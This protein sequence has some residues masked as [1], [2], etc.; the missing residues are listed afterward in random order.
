MA[1]DPEK[2]VAAPA[3]VEYEM[4]NTL[5]PSTDI[6][7]GYGNFWI[8]AKFNGKTVMSN[9]VTVAAVADQPASVAFKKIPE[10]VTV[11]TAYTDN[12]GFEYTVTW[13]SGNTYSSNWPTAPSVTYTYEPTT[14]ASEAKTE[15]V[16][17]KWS[18]NGA[19][20]EIKTNIN[21]VTE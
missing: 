14:S 3:G 1:S 2:K 5:I 11:N 20:G 8:N 16:T 10:K 15:E 12:L 13:K 19:E 17:V 18:C 4:Y 9:A 7:G 21:V 6:A